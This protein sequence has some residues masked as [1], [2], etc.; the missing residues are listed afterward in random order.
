MIQYQAALTFN[1]SHVNRFRK[2]QLGMWRVASS[3][4][5]RSDKPLII[6]IGVIDGTLLMPA[7]KLYS[8]GVVVNP[9]KLLDDVHEHKRNFSGFDN[10]DMMI[11]DGALVAA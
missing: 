1:P 2:G 7:T 3:T 11:K 4:I 5:I 9:K 10:I 8:R 6:K